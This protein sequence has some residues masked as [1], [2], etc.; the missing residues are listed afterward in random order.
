MVYIYSNASLSFYLYTPN[1]LCA[2]TAITLLKI[3]P[4]KAALHL[5]HGEHVDREAVPHPPE[6]TNQWLEQFFIMNYAR[7]FVFL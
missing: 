1:V 3:E 5:L 2:Y 7:F 4:V 6:Q